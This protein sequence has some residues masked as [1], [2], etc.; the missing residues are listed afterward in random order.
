MSINFLQYDRA[1][2]RKIL[3]ALIFAAEEPLSL[4]TLVKFL[5]G[6]NGSE[7]TIFTP[8]GP[9][10][11]LIDLIAEINA[12]LAACQRPY[13][14][15]EIGGGYQFATL[16]EF[17]K[18]ISRYLQLK[19]TRR[20]SRAA[21][22]TLAIIAYRQPV[23][24]PEIDAIRG[25]RSE[26]V[27]QTLLQRELITIVGRA[28]TIGRPL[29]Y[30]T[31]PLFLKTFGLNSLDDLPRLRELDELL[32]EPTES[33]EVVTFVATEE[34][35]ETLEQQFQERLTSVESIEDTP[36]TED[37]NTVTNTH[38]VEPNAGEPKTS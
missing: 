6:N 7:H 13:Q 5:F 33:T 36:V 3:E 35:K 12:E 31:T 9:E 26:E 32:Q 14:I 23:S 15:V 37:N 20:L 1:E 25:V 30:G 28:D 24:K 38:S 11:F 16:P 27:L 29:L 18:I 34:I 2:Q 19:T 8:K 17:G 4:K 10:A 22:E 21:L